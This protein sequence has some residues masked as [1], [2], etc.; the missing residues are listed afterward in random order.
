[1]RTGQR[2]CMAFLCLF[3]VSLSAVAQTD[4]KK[5]YYEGRLIERV[6]DL[7]AKLNRFS[8]AMGSSDIKMMNEK[9]LDL[10]VAYA[11]VYEHASYFEMFNTPEA[12][13]P[14]L[15]ERVPPL[16]EKA[17]EVMPTWILG[18]PKELSTFTFFL[19][20][21]EKLE[22]PAEKAIEGYRDGTTDHAGLFAAQYRFLGNTIVMNLLWRSGEQFGITSSNSSQ[23]ESRVNAVNK[24]MEELDA[25]MDTLE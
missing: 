8:E 2:L 22:A 16:M 23:Y 24:K 25:E 3:L 13:I 17:D 6:D 21:A 15:A 14:T 1:M 19:A 18:L 11:F 12:L 7:E 9:R 20:E 10:F 4:A 5:E